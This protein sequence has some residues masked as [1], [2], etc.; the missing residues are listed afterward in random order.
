MQ[1][2]IAIVMPQ[3]ESKSKVA[4]T[5]SKVCECLTAINAM[6]SQQTS[7]QAVTSYAD[8]FRMLDV[9]WDANVAEN[10]QV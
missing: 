10:F 3:A 8:V 1:E 7:E 4:T 6:L 5:I 2:R 9:L